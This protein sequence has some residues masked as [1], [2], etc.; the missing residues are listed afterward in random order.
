MPEILT[1]S[2]AGIV[3][4]IVCLINNHF[5]AKSAQKSIELEREKVRQ[6]H[7]DTR[8]LI[9]Y[10]LDELTKRVDLHNHVVERVYKLEK[11]SEVQAEKISVANHR[12]EDLEKRKE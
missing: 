11:A 1:G 9:E 6:Q 4:L 12:I 5:Q 8:A 10:K 2:I 7:D 3:T